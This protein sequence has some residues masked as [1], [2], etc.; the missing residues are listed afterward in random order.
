[1]RRPRTAPRAHR[2]PSWALG[3]RAVNGP[4]GRP[5]WG[6]EGGRRPPPSGAFV[7]MIE[8]RVSDRDQM[9]QRLADRFTVEAR[10]GEGAMGQVFRVHDEHE[11]RTVALKLLKPERTEPGQLQRFKREFRAAARL[12]HPYCVHGLDFVEHGGLAMLTMEYVPGGSL[13]THRWE[14]PTA[15]VRLALQLLAGLDHIHG[16]RLVHRD[17]KPSNILIE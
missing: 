3:G 15:V 6:Q 7:A 8:R 2:P 14:R 16:K 4:G 9:P 12:H 17:L 1:G 13:V 10:L 11:G 5:S